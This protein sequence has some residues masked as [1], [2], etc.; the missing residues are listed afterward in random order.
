MYE[1]NPEAWSRSSSSDIAQRNAIP[2]TD[3]DHG[4]FTTNNLWNNTNDHV[5]ETT[6]MYSTSNEVSTDIWDNIQIE[7]DQ[8]NAYVEILK[9]I[10]KVAVIFVAVNISECFI[11]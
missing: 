6:Q 8:K 11:D 2:R 10:R 3:Y 5:I 4:K 9:K 7:K 1:V